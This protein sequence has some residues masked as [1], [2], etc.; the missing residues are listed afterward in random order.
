[1]D[2]STNVDL[3]SMVF[4]LM[5]KLTRATNLIL[6]IVPYKIEDIAMVVGINTLFDVILMS[7]T[8]YKYRSYLGM[9]F[10]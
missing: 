4:N 2:E 7:C 10:P 6:R 5:L 3:Q 8:F 1:M 9:H